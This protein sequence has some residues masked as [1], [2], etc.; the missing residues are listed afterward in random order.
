MKN[1]LFISVSLAI[2]ALSTIA[3]SASGQ[4][5]KV[6]LSDL[7]SDSV[8]VRI[9]DAEGLPKNQ[10]MDYIPVKNGQ[11]VY[12]LKIKT[13]TRAYITPLVKPEK[14]NK[15]RS[16]NQYLQVLLVPGEQA[17]I[18]GTFKKHQ[19]GGS[20]FFREYQKANIPMEAINE[21]LQ[22]LYKK[23]EPVLNV[24]NPNDSIL[25]VFSKERT[26]LFDAQKKEILSYIKN[27]PD[28]DVSAALVSELATKDMNEGVALL[29]T[30]AKDGKLS[31]IYKKT[32]K[33]VQEQKDKEERSK[34]MEG[35]PAPAFSLPG[36]DGK[37][38]SL[39]SF[40]GKYVV[41]D[42]WGS[43]CGWC[44]K[45]IPDM[46]KYYDK[47]KDKMEI[48]SVDCRDTDAKWREAVAKHGLTWTQVRCDG[49]TCNLPSIYNVL[50]YPTKCIIDPQGKLLK[51]VIGESPEF[52]EYLDKLFK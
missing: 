3:P 45:G 8:I 26:A 33:Q 49:E 10:L 39:E 52:Y 9:L 47:Y 32:L 23:Y 14:G 20:A 24:D 43:W 35:N 27:H 6:S 16:L 12:N 25:K 17:T 40:R 15:M 48:V 38:I 5:L 11:F 37:M 28:S 41:V 2:A 21:K 30:R 42:F 7:K 46:K 29:T 4:S 13:A 19:L 34:K 18:T 31:P 44:I 1:K 51:V 50:G 22:A 36:L